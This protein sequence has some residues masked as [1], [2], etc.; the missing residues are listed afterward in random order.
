[1]AESKHPARGPDPSDSE[2]PVTRRFTLVPDEP[3]DAGA[4]PAADSPWARAS[5]KARE[6]AAE[7]LTLV[8]LA[9]ERIAGGE[10]A[11]A[12]D[13]AAAAQ[14][15]VTPRSVRNW[16]RRVARHDGSNRLAALLHRP[17]S[18]RPPKT[19]DGP[20]AQEL[21]R[22]WCTDW[23]REE[24]PDAAAVYRRLTWLAH[25]KGWR[26]PPLSHFK[27]RTR[28]EVPHEE[29]VRARG[30]ALAA[31]NL[32]PHQVRTVAELG[33][34]EIVNGDGR[35]MD[36]MVR[37]PSGREAR[38][39]L[40]LWQDVYTRRILG[41]RVGETESADLVRLTLHDVITAHGVPGCVLVDSTRAA[42][43]KWLTG[44]QRG[45]KRWRSTRE[46]LPGLLKL[47]D[48]RYSATTVD[49]DAAGRGKGRG[50]SKPVERAFGDLARQIDKHPKLAGAYTGPSPAKAP[51]THRM[52]AAPVGDFLDVL[53]RVVREHNAR[54]DRR[55][56]IAA[57]RSFDATWAEAVAGAEIRRL[58]A[59]QASLLL[60]SGEDVRI[61]RDGS[62]RL[63]AGRSEYGANRYHDGSLAERAG[64]WVV[65]RFDPQDLHAPVHVYD[66]AGRYLCLAEC[67]M[68]VGFSDTR[69]ARDYER[70]RK[71]KRKAAERGLA[72]KR[73]MDELLH[74]LDAAAGPPEPEEVAP[75]VTRLVTRRAPVPVPEPADTPRRAVG[76][77]RTLAAVRKLMEEEEL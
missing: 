2:A 24:A 17:V 72:A 38:P 49:R 61:Q 9:E 15:D 62:L 8:R 53:G 46:E 43:A 14:G 45:R 12:A 11:R 30:G 51:E 70:L 4:D 44:G 32:V 19:W 59:A 5:E 13:A 57:G 42:S 21:W 20:G 52:R 63:K 67:L 36:V 66:R 29:Q 69:E 1:M 23:L 77:H 34:L 10:P 65:A 18:G 55:T 76:G 31:M 33:P 39:V 64:E 26:L 75:G 47:L 41:W 54:P 74:G 60:L 73:D 40:W 71:R 37:W 27:A 35:R 25:D 68:P 3:A 7:R 48:I 56:E 50:R 16:R 22:A 28:R 58:T 6:A